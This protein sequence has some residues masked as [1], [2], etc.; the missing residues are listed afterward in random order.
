M[1]LV[2][3]L[4]LLWTAA[5]MDDTRVA[6][7]TPWTFEHTTALA[8][9][10]LGPEERVLVAARDA[11][12]RFWT[13]D[14]KSGT[15]V[16]GP[17]D[18]FPIQPAPISLENVVYM[19]TTVGN[20]IRVDLAGQ[21]VGTSSAPWG[22]TSPIVL[23]SDD[24]FRLGTTTGHALALDTETNVLFDVDL[25]APIATAP[26]VASDET[27]YYATDTGRLVGVDPAGSVVL[28][29]SVENPAS[30]PSVFEDRVAVG[31]GST[32]TAFDRDTGLVIFSRPRGAR[33]VGTRFLSDGTLLAWGEDGRL[34]L[35]DTGG[36]PVFSYD[37]GPPIYAPAIQAAE[38]RFGLVDSQGW[39]HLIRPNGEALYTLQLAGPPLEQAVEISEAFALFTIDNRIQAV[40]FDFKP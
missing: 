12:G 3:L 17:F 36:Q 40:N 32:V 14:Q 21:A 7:A 22:R 35:L 10:G 16:E 6:I 8:P 11:P 23:A 1:R 38:G 2:A 20:I 5:C 13:L 31:G 18:T 26:A 9:P 37:A 33:V 39:A 30:G 27:T 19:V 24:T 4:F 34:E 25:E 29:V 28:D 15:L